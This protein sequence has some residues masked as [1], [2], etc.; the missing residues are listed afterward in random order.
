MSVIKCEADARPSIRFSRIRVIQILRLPR[1]AN[2]WHLSASP[3]PQEGT[4]RVVTERWRGLRWTLRRQAG[5]SRRTKT[6]QRTA[7]S[8]G[9]GAATLASIRPACAGAATVTIKAAH[10]GE[11]EGN[12]KTIA[13]GKP[14]CFG[15]TCSSTPVLSLHGD[16]GRSRRPAFP[17]PS[18]RRGTPNLQNPDENKPRE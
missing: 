10:R 1:R 4:K 6:P 14:G 12:R 17:A 8:C 9:P 5:F 16:Y 3:R 7:K 2:Q 15:C 11:H 13:R 18:S